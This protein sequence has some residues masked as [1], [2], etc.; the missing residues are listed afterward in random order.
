MMPTSRVSWLLLVLSWSVGLAVPVEAQERAELVAALAARS[1]TD[2]EFVRTSLFTWTSDAQATRL[3]TERRLL[4]TG[5]AG[6]VSRSPYQRALDALIA[7][8]TAHPA[9]AALAR[10]LT[11]SPLPGA[12]RYAWTTPYGPVLPRRVRSYGPA[13]VRIEL[14]SDA[15]HA[16]FAPDERPAFRVV[17]ARGATVS[18]ADVLAAPGRLASVLHVRARDPHGAYRE[19]IVHGGVRCWSLGTIEVRDRIEE[20]RRLLVALDRAL[21]LAGARRRPPPMLEAWRARLGSQGD[22]SSA[23]AWLTELRARWAAT[24]PFDT[25]RHAL[26]RSSL[27]ALAEALA[28]RGRPVVTPAEECGSR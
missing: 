26:T 28:L 21:A 15:W 22:P 11:Q 13:L 18:A 5:A 12:P 4:T 24:M 8:G 2:D 9:D 3:A 14:G 10:L 25:P 1:L 16:R 23:G 6:G 19:I 17:D 7:S 20:D 27:A